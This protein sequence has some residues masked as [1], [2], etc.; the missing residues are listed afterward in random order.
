[1]ESESEV[2]AL[3]HDYEISASTFTLIVILF[4]SSVML[5]GMLGIWYERLR[6]LRLDSNKAKQYIVRDSLKSEERIK[7]L[8]KV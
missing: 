8:T 7:T 4:V 3:N 6:K 1:M 2:G 5:G